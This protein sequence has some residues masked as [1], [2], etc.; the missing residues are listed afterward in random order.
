M[1]YTGRMPH[2]PSDLL[3]EINWDKLRSDM[4]WTVDALEWAHLRVET[5][6]VDRKEAYPTIARALED[7]CKAQIAVI[8]GF[9][10]DKD[11]QHD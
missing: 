6:R 2:D 3:N 7:L 5:G 11:G 1:R 4:V 8:R 10:L 9:K